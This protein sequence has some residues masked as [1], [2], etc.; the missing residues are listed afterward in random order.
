MFIDVHCHLDLL[1]DID[2]AIEMARKKKVRVIVCNGI[3]IEVNRKVLSLCEKFKEVKA[4]LGVYPIDALK[5]K[6]S[7]INKE[8]EFMRNS[9]SNIVAIGEVGLDFKEDL[10]NWK[11]QKEIF[12]RFILLA[13]EL[14]KPVIVH[15]RKAEN[16]CVNILEALKA[17]RVIMHCFCGKF[18][19]VER[20]VGNGWFL[21]I[22]T[23]V[24]YSEQ[25]QNI[26]KKVSIDNLLCETDSPFLHPLRKGDNS[27]DNVIYSY[28]MI[29]KLK[30]MKLKDVEKRIW[31]NFI[32]VFY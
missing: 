10:N 31:E 27:P 32:K 13:I 18:S 28:K 9:K 8:I 30:G 20:I 12:R 5:L 14:D 21:S 3:N 16:D 6:D 15:S 2:K 29:S 25:F 17:R 1:K 23:N 26:V 11:R 7:R 24:C 4:A 22:P 19:L